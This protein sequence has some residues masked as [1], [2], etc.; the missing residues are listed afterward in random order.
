MVQLYVAIGFLGRV[1]L[2][3]RSEPRDAP[4]TKPMM[5][6]RALMEKSTDADLLRE[7]IGFA[8]ERLVELEVGART[9]ADHGE[10]SCGGRTTCRNGYRDRSLDT[11]LGTLNLRAPKL[12]QGRYFPDFLGARKTSEEARIGSVSTRR[13][14][15]LVQA[16]GLSGFS[17]STVSKLC[18]DIDERVGEFLNRLLTGEWP[19]AWLEPPI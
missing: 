19:H 7:M 9:G 6:L 16:M 17:K 15:E 8:A 2:Q 4:K 11:R 3:H 1:G 10:K 13:V 5:D 14:D 12:R 18:K